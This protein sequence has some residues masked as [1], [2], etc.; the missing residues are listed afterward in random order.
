M[1]ISFVKGSTYKP[2]KDEQRHRKEID[3]DLAKIFAAISPG[4]GTGGVAGSDASFI[5]VSAEGNLAKERVLTAGANITL[6]D[7]GANS[8][9]T[10]K[11]IPSG[12][13]TY[14]QFNDG[15][16]FGAVVA[17]VYTKP[18]GGG[19]A[20]SS[21]LTL[22][23]TATGSGS[24][25][26]S[27][28]GGSGSTTGSGNINFSDDKANDGTA[29]LT[30]QNSINT[31]SP[32]YFQFTFPTQA[33][34]NQGGGTEKFISYW[35][36][37]SS[38]GVSNLSTLSDAVFFNINGAA[39]PH[40]LSS[41]GTMA[42]FL[43]TKI[44]APQ[45]NGVAGGATETITNAATVYISGAPNGSNITF[46]NGPYALW[47]AGGAVRF[48]G[49]IVH[50]NTIDYASQAA[51]GS[52]VEGDMWNDST[53]KAIIVYVD[54]VKQTLSTGLFVSTG[55]ATVANTVT[56]TTIIGSGV[57]T[58]TLPA[59]FLVAGKTIRITAKGYYG[60]TGTPTINI[61]VKLGSTVVMSTGAQTQALNITSQ[62]FEA[63][64]DITCRTVGAGGT[65]YGQGH[66]L[67][68][69]T[70]V[71]T[72]VEEMVNTATTT[73]DTTT[74]QAVGL[75]A[76]WGTASASNTITGTNFTL[77]VLN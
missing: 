74:T 65:V 25:T 16:V 34:I 10:V 20:S 76:T 17:F 57:G 39:T 67:L 37:R 64:G 70:A 43:F 56:E 38:T 7:A 28:V 2:D 15:G 32:A 4:S 9:M 73:I 6:T 35:D 13:D 72:T 77:E 50:N 44:T 45:I 3:A 68:A 46:T 54:A 1:T 42:N 5:T 19:A 63:S 59:N 30:Y 36:F 40:T 27:L 14:V 66:A 47:I 12:S 41:G 18:Q 71:A 58:L 11:A 52:P 24:G 69:T 21:V 26:L 53:Q 8:T 23:A 49:T 60:T 62:Y 61:K 33:T 29:L 75:T 55:D 22:T 48:D 51:P 31:V